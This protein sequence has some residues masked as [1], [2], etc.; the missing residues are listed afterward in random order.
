[1]NK[2]QNSDRIVYHISSNWNPNE[3]VYEILNTTTSR[4]IFHCYL[5]TVGY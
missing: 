1:M 5:F 2:I 3:P 4:G